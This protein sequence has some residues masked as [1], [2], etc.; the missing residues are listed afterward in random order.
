MEVAQLKKYHDSALPLLG[1]YHTQRKTFK[2][3]S[4]LL[5]SLQHCTIAKVWI[6]HKCSLIDEWIKPTCDIYM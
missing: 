3:I 6:K 4:A 1:I 5:R 2:K